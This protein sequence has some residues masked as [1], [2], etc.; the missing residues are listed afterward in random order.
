MQPGVSPSLPG[1][2]ASNKYATSPLCDAIVTSGP[3]PGQDASIRHGSGL[4][5]VREDSGVSTLAMAPSTHAR[6]A[7]TAELDAAVAVAVAAARGIR[8][9]LQLGDGQ[10]P[11]SIPYR[12]ARGLTH[13]AGE[14]CFQLFFLSS[15]LSFLCRVGCF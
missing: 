3:E 7:T 9:H 12:T 6:Q 8:Q 10:R 5:A 11:S 15:A 13:G 14:A 4:E 2:A 1:C